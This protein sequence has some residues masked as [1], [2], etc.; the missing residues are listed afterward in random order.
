MRGGAIPIFWQPPEKSI[1]PSGLVRGCRVGTFV[2]V[3]DHGGGRPGKDRGQK[4]A[5]SAYIAE[6]HDQEGVR[7]LGKSLSYVRDQLGLDPAAFLHEM[8]DG[9]LGCNYPVPPR[10]LDISE[11]IVRQY[12]IREMGPMQFPASP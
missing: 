8:V 1:F 12:I 2:F 4:G 9:I 6:N 7:F 10:M 5:S 3:Y 11:K